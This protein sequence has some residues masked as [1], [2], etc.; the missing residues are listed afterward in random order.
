MDSA[1]TVITIIL[2]GVLVYQDINYRAVSW[3]LF[4]ILFFLFLFATLLEENFRI[5]LEYTLTNCLFILFQISLVYLYF[6][7][8]H[9]KLINIT[10][11][12]IGIGDLLFF[13]AVTPYLALPLFVLYIVTGMF[14]TLLVYSAFVWFKRIDRHSY[15]I[16]LAGIL[17]GYMIILKTGQWLFPELINSFIVPFDKYLFN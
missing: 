8:K 12:L 1:L 7:F 14:L 6:C 2:L 16:P 13:I 11:N 10:N 5:A 17:A 15:P 3:L 4:P 9:K